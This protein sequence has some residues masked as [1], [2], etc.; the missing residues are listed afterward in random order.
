ML[1]PDKLI[2]KYIMKKNILF[3]LILGLLFLVSFPSCSDYKFIEEN[4]FIGTWELIGRDI[5]SG[6]VIKIEEKDNQ[7]VGK[8]VELPNNI[9]GELFL[10]K[11]DIWVS[12]IKRSANYYFKVTELK[13]AKDLFSTYDLPANNEYYAT[14]SEDKKS[15][16]LTTKTPNANVKKSSVLYKKIS[17]R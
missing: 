4:E 14:F 3:N 8:I 16:Y 11:G 1:K 2:N 12:Q 6:M 15:V 7:L 13:I 9:Y 5:Y 17:G 10:K